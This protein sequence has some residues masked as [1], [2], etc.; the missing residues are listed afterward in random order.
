MF[1]SPELIVPAISPGI[2]ITSFKKSGCII[3]GTTIRQATKKD[4]AYRLKKFH[5][6]RSSGMPIPANRLDELPAACFSPIVS[7]PAF[8]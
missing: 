3:A 4:A 8:S 2:W 5:H 6:V 1:C 7:L